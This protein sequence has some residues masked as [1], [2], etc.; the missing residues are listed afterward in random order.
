MMHFLYINISNFS[1]GWTDWPT[2][3]VRKFSGRDNCLLKVGLCQISTYQMNK[4][5]R[6]IFKS[7][8]EE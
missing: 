4:K 7:I 8:V 6:G 1:V 2:A 3:N 5:F